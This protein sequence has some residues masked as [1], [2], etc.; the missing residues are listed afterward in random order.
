MTAAI[1]AFPKKR[2]LQF[3]REFRGGMVE[4]LG[5]YVARM[6]GQALIWAERGEPSA[7]AIYCEAAA[8]MLHREAL[9][10]YADDGRASTAD[11]DLPGMAEAHRKRAAR[12]TPEKT[13][14]RRERALRGHE[15]RRRNKAARDAE[16]TPPPA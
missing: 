5:M 14:R 4:P 2:S 15:T 8:I 12:T 6:T 9:E 10:R 11:A 3:P 7:A 16:M 1:V 13:Q